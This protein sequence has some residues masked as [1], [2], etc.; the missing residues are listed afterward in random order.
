VLVTRNVRHFDHVTG[1]KIE[2]WFE[3]PATAAS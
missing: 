3:P 2:N 1:L